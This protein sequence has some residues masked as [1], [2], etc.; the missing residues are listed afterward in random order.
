M[1]HDLA[2]FDQV[3]ASLYVKGLSTYE[4]AKGLQVS[5]GKVARALRRVGMPMRPLSRAIRNAYNKK[6]AG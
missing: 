2:M 5:Q 4:I 6:A 1:T 3:A